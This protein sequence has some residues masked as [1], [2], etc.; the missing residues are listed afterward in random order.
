MKLRE[1]EQALARANPLE[2]SSLDGL[3]LRLAEDELL[4]AILAEPRPE[5]LR[6]KRPARIRRR[7]LL[8]AA[9]AVLAVLTALVVGLPG[10]GDEGRPGGLAVLDQVAAAAAEQPP[11][12][13]ALPYGYL[14]TRGNYANTTSYG[15]ESWSVYHSEIVETWA[16]PDGSGLRRTVSFDRGFVSPADRE[17]WVRAGRPPFLAHGWGRHVGTE[18]FG[19]GTFAGKDSLGADLATLPTDP[20]ELSRWLIDR[21]G[22]T[23][24]GFPLS[25]KTLTLVAELLQNPF[26]PPELRASLYEAEALVPG[27][28]DLGPA[29]D[30]LGREGIAVGARS[31]NSG[32]PTLYSLIVDPDTSAV[33]ATEEKQL[34]APAALP[35]LDEP[36][37]VSSTAYLES[38]RTASIPDF[39]G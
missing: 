21:A 27:I 24:N 3:D 8:V 13:A 37:V 36:L 31:A 33:L 4:A 11:P 20:E 10:G 38:R 6:P 18:T 16:A 23:G 29:R 9:A 25:V 19:P 30:L 15:G 28:E 14:K 2:E 17:A 34:R 12:G 7:P 22:E 1:A 5:P 26:A 39:G 32:A 35:E